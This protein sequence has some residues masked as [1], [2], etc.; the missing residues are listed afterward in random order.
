[1][2]TELLL[3]GDLRLLLYSVFLC[4]ILWI[5]YVLSIIGTRGLTKAVGYPTGVYDDLP[6]WAQRAQRAHLNLVENLAPFAVLVLVAH[7][8]GNANEVTLLGARLFFWARVAH[9]V[10][11]IAGIAWLRTLAFAASWVGCIMILGQMIY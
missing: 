8:T 2:K 1:M 10:T 6:A 11:C 9:A 3:T 4:L 7:L 5:P